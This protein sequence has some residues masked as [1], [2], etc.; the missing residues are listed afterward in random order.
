M[1]TPDNWPTS[2]AECNVTYNDSNNYNN[3]PFLIF[4]SEYD[5]I[6]LV[7]HFSYFYH[8]F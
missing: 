5:K 7:N 3:N 8:F 4:Y 2:F 1:S 6:F